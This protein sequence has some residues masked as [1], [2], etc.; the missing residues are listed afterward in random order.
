[1][2]VSIAEKCA[3]MIGIVGAIRGNRT[4]VGGMEPGFVTLRF[5]R[6]TTT[7]Q[8]AMLLPLLIVITVIQV[9]PQVDLPETA[10]HEETAPI[11]IKSRAVA[12]PTFAVVLQRTVQDSV[13]STPLIAGETSPRAAHLLNRSPLIL[14]STLLC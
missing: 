2:L 3:I 4:L 10:F 8:M 13:Q 9:L 12:A 14:F 5:L 1:M 7:V 6:M 11:V